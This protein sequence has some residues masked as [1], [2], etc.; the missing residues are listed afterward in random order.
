MTTDPCIF[1]GSIAFEIFSNSWT[2]LYNQEWHTTSHSYGAQFPRVQW[3][4][5]D[6]WVPSSKACHQ[7][8]LQRGQ[9]CAICFIRSA[10]SSWCPSS[11]CHCLYSPKP[12]GS[13]NWK[14]GI[15]LTCWTPLSIKTTWGPC[16]PWI[17]IITHSYVTQAPP[18]TLCRRLHLERKVSSRASL[19]KSIISCQTTS[20]AVWSS[21]AHKARQNQ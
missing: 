9:T 6:E 20:S 2:P 5:P 10:L 3:V 15:F 11:R 1:S 12:W 7:T 13:R 18:M 16:R 17:M 21:P 4:L 14:K 19:G 8:N